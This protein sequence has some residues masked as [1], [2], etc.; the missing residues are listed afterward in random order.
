MVQPSSENG[1]LIFDID[2]CSRPPASD[3][4]AALSILDRNMTSR[5]VKFYRFDGAGESIGWVRICR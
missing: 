5:C 1:N 3:E 2:F 4:D